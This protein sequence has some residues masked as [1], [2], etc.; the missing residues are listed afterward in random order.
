MCWFNTPAPVATT[1]PAP[2]SRT[3]A[4]VQSAAEAV[5]LQLAAT[6]SPSVA[7]LGATGSAGDTSKPKVLGVKLGA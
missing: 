3:S 4:D 6:R 1:A 7:D 2:V 5:R